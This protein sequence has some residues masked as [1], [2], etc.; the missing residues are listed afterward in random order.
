MRTRPDSISSKDYKWI[1][2]LKDHFTKY[3]WTKPLEHKEAKEVY[4]S[5]REIF[6]TFGPPHILQSDNGTEFVNHLINSLKD[7]FPG[8]QLW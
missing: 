4:E 3:C 2:Q 5:I 6:L 8:T 1:L 7:D